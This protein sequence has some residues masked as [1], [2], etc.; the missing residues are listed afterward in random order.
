MIPYGEDGKCKRCL[1]GRTAHEDTGKRASDAIRQH[2][3]NDRELAVGSWIALRL[4]DG[5]S[6]RQLYPTKSTA[7]EYQLHETQCAYVVIPPDGMSKQDAE[8]FICL[9]RQAYANGVPLAHPDNDVLTIG[10][11]VI[12]L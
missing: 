1:L 9:M 8:A 5:G 4:S 11:R 7:I 12:R 2:I 6:D 3:S 10:G